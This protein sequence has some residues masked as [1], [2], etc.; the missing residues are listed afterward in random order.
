MMKLLENGPQEGIDVPP[1]HK[2]VVWVSYYW[3]PNHH[4]ASLMHIRSKWWH[5]LFPATVYLFTKV[6]KN[7]EGGE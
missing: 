6:V 5:L 3:D 1:G 2:V 4:A 7:D